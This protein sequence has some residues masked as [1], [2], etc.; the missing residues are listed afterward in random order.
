MVVKKIKVKDAPNCK[1]PFY[2]AEFNKCQATWP[3]MIECKI[4]HY[5]G[6]VPIDCPLHAS[7]IIVS[8]GAD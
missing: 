4:A 3:E 2:N 1:C 7:D 8:L 5:N 6:K